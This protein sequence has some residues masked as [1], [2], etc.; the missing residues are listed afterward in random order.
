MHY[1]CQRPIETFTSQTNH[2]E[3]PE[4]NATEREWC[5]KL[6]NRRDILLTERKNQEEKTKNVGHSQKVLMILFACVCLLGDICIR[7]WTM[8]CHLWLSFFV[9]WFV[10]LHL[11]KLKIN[12]LTYSKQSSHS[13]NVYHRIFFFLNVIIIHLVELSLSR[14]RWKL[15]KNINTRLFST[16]KWLS[17]NEW[18]NERAEKL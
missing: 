1:L 5:Q 17:A 6:I 4:I 7:C 11:M 3:Q 12:I 9:S 16:W 15:A 8:L 10:E 13:P 14:I 18:M 2:H